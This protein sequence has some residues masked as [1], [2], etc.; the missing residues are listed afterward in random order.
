MKFLADMGVSQRTVLWLRQ[1][2]HDA[3]HLREEKLHKLPDEQILEK[4]LREGRIVLTF[5]L[6]FGEIMAKAGSSCPSV[7]I[8][9]LADGTP[10]NVNTHLQKVLQDNSDQLAA[11]AIISVEEKKHRVRL[12]PIIFPKAKG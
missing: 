2:G 3:V 10:M 4:G 11:G 8:F 9:R 6:D 1:M 5:D 12:L 7:I